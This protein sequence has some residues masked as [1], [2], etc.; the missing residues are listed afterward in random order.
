MV[1]A[2]PSPVC[3]LNIINEA[4]NISAAKHFNYPNGSIN[5]SVRLQSIIWNFSP[6]LNQTTVKNAQMV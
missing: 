1:F 5:F 3:F 4:P 6:W 2:E